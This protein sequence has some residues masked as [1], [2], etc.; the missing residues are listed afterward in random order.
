MFK[1]IYLFKIYKLDQKISKRSVLSPLQRPVKRIFS[2]WNLLKIWQMPN[3]TTLQVFSKIRKGEGNLPIFGQPICQKLQGRN[4]ER[5]MLLKQKWLHFQYFLIWLI[6]M[7]MQI[8]FS[9]IC[10]IERQHKIQKRTHSPFF[11]DSFSKPE[12]SSSVL[13]PNIALEKKWVRQH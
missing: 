11:F 7:R 2:A 1:N 10:C 13:W 5:V 3:W 6:W 8:E 4:F 9:V 12:S